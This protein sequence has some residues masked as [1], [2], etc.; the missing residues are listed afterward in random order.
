M[1]TFR[2]ASV[3]RRV[4]P[5]LIKPDGHT[6]ELAP[7]EQVSLELPADFNDVHL[8]PVTLKDKPTSRDTKETA[9]ADNADS[10]AKEKT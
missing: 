10:T 2:N 5:N 6:L 4:W 1:R 7:N 3:E 8:V 9:S